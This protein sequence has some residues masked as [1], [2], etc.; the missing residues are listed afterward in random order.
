M[1]YRMIIKFFGL[2]LLIEAGLVLVPIPA[3]LVFG[4][5]AL[6]FIFTALIL[7]AFALPMRLIKPKNKRIYA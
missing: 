3:A 4:E 5:S 6:P 2:V 1:N 7:F